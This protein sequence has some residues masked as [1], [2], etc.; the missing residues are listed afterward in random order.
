MGQRSMCVSEA[1]LLTK[2]S[3]AA[4]ERWALDPTRLAAMVSRGWSFV[5]RGYGFGYFNY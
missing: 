1:F 2:R 4:A 5:A 3:E